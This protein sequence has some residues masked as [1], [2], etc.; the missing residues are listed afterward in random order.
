MCGSIACFFMDMCG[1]G[2]DFEMHIYSVILAS[3]AVSGFCDGIK[4]TNVSGNS[5]ESSMNA[6]CFQQQVLEQSPVPDV[7]EMAE[8]KLSMSTWAHVQTAINSAP[9]SLQTHSLA[10]G[11]G[12]GKLGSC[13]SIYLLDR[14]TLT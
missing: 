1:L 8:E 10:G 14:K 3:K 13:L 6:R 7:P 5:E 11:T 9:Q 2:C 12:M 4:H